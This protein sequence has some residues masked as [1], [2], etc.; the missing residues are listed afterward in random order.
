LKRHFIFGRRIKTGD[1]LQLVHWVIFYSHSSEHPHE[2]N[3]A[4]EM[5]DLTQL[6]GKQLAGPETCY[7]LVISTDMGIR[8]HKQNF[9]QK[10]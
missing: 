1:Y 3:Q 7:I 4:W 10:V 9:G 6:H 2:F 8:K 5:R